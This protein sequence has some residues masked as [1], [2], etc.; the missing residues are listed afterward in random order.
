MEELRLFEQS[1]DEIDDQIETTR[2]LINELRVIQKRIGD[3]NSA[4]ARRLSLSK[5]GWES[6][7]FCKDDRRL[8]LE[9]LARIANANGHPLMAARKLALSAATATL[10]ARAINEGILDTHTWCLLVKAQ[11]ACNEH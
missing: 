4:F 10:G 8:Q 2:A 1:V 11:G 6:I 7:K 9:T 3:S 5:R